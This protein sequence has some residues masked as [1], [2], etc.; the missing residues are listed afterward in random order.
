MAV[1]EVSKRAL[2]ERF[3]LMAEEDRGGKYSACRL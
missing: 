1:P 2:L 3:G